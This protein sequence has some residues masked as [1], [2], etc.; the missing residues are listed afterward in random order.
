M[1]IFATQ[2]HFL[3]LGRKFHILEG[4]NRKFPKLR[5]SISKKCIVRFF[6]TEPYR[7]N[8]ELIFYA[9]E[10]WRRPLLDAYR[11]KSEF[12]IQTQFKNQFCA[13][14]KM[15]DPAQNSQKAIKRDVFDWFWDL[16][17][18]KENRRKIHRHRAL[19]DEFRTDFL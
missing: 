14:P 17:K 9:N 11:K 10:S 2:K 6:V 1:Y 7:T 16:K 5:G 3:I 4:Q 12:G 13:K 15:S 19:Q 8:F 18:V